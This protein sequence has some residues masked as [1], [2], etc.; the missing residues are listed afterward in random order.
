MNHYRTLG[1]VLAAML[2]APLS[3]SAASYEWTFNN[4]TLGDAFALGTMQ[5]VGSTVPNIIDTNGTTIPHIG[6]AP[7]KVLSVPVF[8]NDA[9]G[10]N[11]ALNATGPNG[12]GLYVNQYTFI[13]DVYSPGAANWRALIQTDPT[14]ASGNDADWYIANDNSLGIA[15]L[16]Y[17]AADIIQQETWYRIALAVDLS[18]GRVTYYVDGVPVFQG[19][20]GIK[21]GRF[22]LYSNVDPGDD[23]RL[24]NEGDTSGNYTNEMYIN[25][26]AFVDREMTE[27]EL[28]EL[29]AP[30]ATGILVPEPAT[31]ILALTGLVLPFLRRRRFAS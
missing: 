14:N 18:E 24:F 19:F 27:V 6:G 2:S 10:F 11:L 25:S 7:A 16:G 26:V 20:S 30:K 9:D 5:A 28:G 31:G 13:F 17:T 12:T 4:G 15:A 3:A 8:N 21:D 29:G 1:L 23:V 22:A